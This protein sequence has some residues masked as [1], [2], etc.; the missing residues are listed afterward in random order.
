MMCSDKPLREILLFVE[1]TLSSDGVGGG[2]GGGGGTKG[3]TVVEN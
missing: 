1:C 2:G 3:L